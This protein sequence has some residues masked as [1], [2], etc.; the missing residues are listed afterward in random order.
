MKASE[1]KQIAKTMRQY[2]IT[3]VRMGD[4][5]IEMG[6]QIGNGHADAAPRA[7]VAV[8]APTPQSNP[9][10]HKVEQMASLM[11]LSDVE[12]VDE[13]FPDQTDPGSDDD[14]DAA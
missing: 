13:L 12:L 6:G 10:E 4:A 14:E 7:P 8:N 2:G 9:I 5:E 11:R 3:R 1:F